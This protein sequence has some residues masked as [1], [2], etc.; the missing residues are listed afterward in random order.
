MNRGDRL[1]VEPGALVRELEPK[2]P[3]RIVKAKAYALA[4]DEIAIGVSGLDWF[5]AFACWNRYDLPLKPIVNARG[6]HIEATCHPEATKRMR[7]GNAVG[8]WVLWKDFD[9]SLPQWAQVLSLGLPGL[10]RRVAECRRDTSYYRSLEIAADASLRLVGRLASQAEKVAAN[11]GG[12]RA[13]RQAEC[14]RQLERGAP[15]TAYEAMQLIYLYFVMSE[16]LDA[17]QCRSL[18]VIDQTL[19]PFYRDDLAKGRTTE[20]EFREQLF[21]FFGQWGSID[22]YWGRPA[23]VAV[24][25]ST[26]MAKI[27]AYVESLLRTEYDYVRR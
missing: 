11:G 22:N 6:A 10:R 21:H 19:W 24:Q 14:L 5:P 4:C 9:H 13:A 18:S 3:W 20:S 2:E 23:Q 27:D 8:E 7:A 1:S 26:E 12:V 25:D 16:H 15:R 17:M